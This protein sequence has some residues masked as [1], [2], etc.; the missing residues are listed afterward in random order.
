MSH[1]YSPGKRYQR[2][3]RCRSMEHLKRHQRYDRQQLRTYWTFR[4]SIAARGTPVILTAL[5][6]ADHAAHNP[7]RVAFLEVERRPQATRLQGRASSLWACF[8][9]HKAGKSFNAK[10]AA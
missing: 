6:R 9:T 3:R 8:S 5:R 4:Y 1:V 10:W 2:W 7:L